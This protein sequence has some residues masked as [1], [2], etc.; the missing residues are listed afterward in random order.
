[1]REKEERWKM[2]DGEGKEEEGNWWQKD[3]NSHYRCYAERS[4]IQLC[5][6]GEEKGGVFWVP[7]SESVLDTFP[8]QEK[9]NCVIG[10]QEIL[11]V[12][13]I[14]GRHTPFTLSLL[15]KL[16]TT[17]RGMCKIIH[18]HFFLFF[19]PVRFIFYHTNI[20]WIIRRKMDHKPESQIGICRKLG[21]WI[22]STLYAPQFTMYHL[23]LLYSFWYK[24]YFFSRL[25][26]S[27]LQTVFL[28]DFLVLGY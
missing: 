16:Q 21:V 24:Y 10:C 18:S 9:S 4:Q 1:M 11:A 7:L 13:A 26:K 8:Y 20:G 14:I 6:S 25:F 2:K 27:F 12:P 19:L 5:T 23:F 3:L 15:V 17:N 28:L 22:Y